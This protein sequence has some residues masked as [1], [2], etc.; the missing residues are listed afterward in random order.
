M[1]PVLSQTTSLILIGVLVLFAIPTGVLLK[2]S[3]RNPAWALLC[4]IPVLALIGLW[5]LAFAGGEKT[6][7]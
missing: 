6:D 4:L 5:V 1:M 7:A 3:G 2:R